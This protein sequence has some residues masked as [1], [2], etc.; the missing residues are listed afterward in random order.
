MDSKPMT[1]AAHQ[2]QQVQQ[3][4]DALEQRMSKYDLLLTK[5]EGLMEYSQERTDKIEILLDKMG[6]LQDKANDAITRL[7]VGN[8]STQRWIT[9]AVSL[10]MLIGGVLLGHYLFH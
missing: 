2:T 9:F 3:R 8:E 7:Q 4:I 5:M 1:S 6:D 10:C